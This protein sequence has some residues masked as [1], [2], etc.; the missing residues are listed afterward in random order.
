MSAS[1]TKPRGGGFL[2]ESVQPDDIFT[3]EDLNEEQHAIGATVDQFWSNEVEPALPAIHALKPGAA[4]A[5]LRKASELGLMAISIPEKYG[6][7]ELELASTLVIAEHVAR[8]ASYMMWEGGHTMLGTLPLLYFG[9]EEQKQ[10]YLPKLARLDMLTAY[11]LSEAQSGSDALGVR[12]RADLNSEGTHYILNGQKMWVSSGSDADLFIVFAK[13]GGEQ[14]TCFLVERGFPGVKTGANEHKMG[15][16]GSSTTALYLDDVPV[17]VGNVLGEVGRGHIVAFNILNLGRLKLGASVVGAAK[18]VLEISIK[19]AKQRKAFGSSISEF[20]AIQHKL[21]EM[22]IR[23]FA[24]ESVVWRTAG[25]IE[26]GTSGVGWDNPNAASIK[27]AAIKEVA[28]E[29]SMVKVFGSEMLD[30]VADEGV[31]IHGGYGYHEDYAVE[32]IY[33]DSRINRI[34]EGTNE[35]NRLLI[36]RMVLKSG[37]ATGKQPEAAGAGGEGLIHSAKT[38]ALWSLDLAQ[39]AYPITLDTEQEVLMHLADIL[40]ETYAMESAL[41]RARKIEASRPETH[42]SEIATAFLLD[43]MGRLGYSARNLVGRC[44]DDAALQANTKFVQKLTN[45]LPMDTVQLR[46]NIAVRLIDHE[47]YVI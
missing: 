4:R 35:I 31:Q 25:M 17:P 20:G 15:L 10:H 23:I 40:I 42:A 37:I 21:A 33:R 36:P 18:D 24:T 8:D 16:R 7:L 38:L 44:S 27:L 6:G 45:H 43:A 47:R 26:A 13:V 11:A 30:Y 1:N 14:F 34:F 41:L 28:V 9:T 46:R 19:Y 12:T 5:V 3:A 32:R 39:K 29:C 22:A 2:T